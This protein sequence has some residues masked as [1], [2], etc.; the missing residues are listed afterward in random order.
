MAPDRGG[1]SRFDSRSGHNAVNRRVPD[2][3]APALRKGDLLA[4]VDLGSNSFR[5]L[6]ARWEGGELRPVDRLREV[7][8]LAAGL[9]P[10]GGL[11]AKKRKEALDC[12]ARFGQRLSSVP[13]C[14]VRAVA[15]NTVRQMRAPLRFL[16]AA[17]H[18]LGHVIEVVSGREEGRL[19]WLGVTH[20]LPRSDQ[21][22]LVI[23]IGGGSTEIIMGQ[24][25]EPE[26]T[27][28][29]QAGCVASSLRFFP[30]GRITAKRWQRAREELGVLMQ[31]FAAEYRER[32]WS[33]AWGTSGTMQ[34]IA[35]IAAG[36]GDP[37]NSI[38]RKSL[39]RMR[40]AL[41][42]AG[43][44]RA[45]VLPGLAGD[46]R[47]SI[48]A[49][50][51]I[52][53][54][55]FDALGLD[56]IGVSE[57]ALR[58][59]LLWDMIGRASGHDP[60]VASLGGLAR[61]CGIDAAQAQ[62]VEAR[63]LALFDKVASD[64]RLDGR[65]R[66]W[67]AWSARVHELGMSI[68]HSHHQRH[69][70]YILLHSD[71]AGFSTLDQQVLATIVRNHRRKPAPEL[72][73]ALPARMRVPVARVTCLLRLAV[74]LC[75]TREEPGASPLRVFVRGKGIHVCIPVSWRRSR[76]L[77]VADLRTEKNMLQGLGVR[78]ELDFARR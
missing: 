12:L 73:E 37:A 41:L 7:I 68:S 76:P 31:Q 65:T 74:L 71:L 5:L 72:L 28:S 58:E 54:V 67:L 50:I 27:E 56:Q 22:R 8:R 43:S 23:D 49:G 18:A 75:R 45:V 51:A 70:S 44:A 26:L 52:A 15:T 30:N 62:R 61:R 48:A 32:R 69:A 6:V 21:R 20:A 10:D 2:R 35:S 77:T 25:F 40:D 19:I 42:R 34:A 46:R 14:R 47:P 4:S 63:A 1:R 60:R 78:L 9:G 55:L 38:T 64:W 39:G 24:G 16:K 29:V 33:E 59:G 11:D 57:G 66:G 36:M 13:A 53:E 3:G 17:E